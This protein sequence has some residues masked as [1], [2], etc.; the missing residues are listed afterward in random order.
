MEADL[1]AG[2]RGHQL[3]VLERGVRRYCVDRK[4]MLFLKWDSRRQG[5]PGTEWVDRRSG[6]VERDRTA[7][8]YTISLDALRKKEK[9]DEPGPERDDWGE[10]S[11][12]QVR[13]LFVVAVTP[14]N[15][16]IYIVL[17]YSFP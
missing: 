5:K 9:A 4:W 3:S 11:F 16:G 15:K 17:L 13:W 7:N 6:R 8:F 14:S 10:V 12:G 1:R 2:R